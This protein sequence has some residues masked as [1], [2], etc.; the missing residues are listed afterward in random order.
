M[1]SFLAKFKV[2]D[3]FRRRPSKRILLL[4][5]G[6]AGKTTILRRL[7]SVVTDQL[8][9]GWSV[10]SVQCKHIEFVSWK[11][12]VHH[13]MCSHY[14]DD[15]GGIIFVVDSCIS[16]TAKDV[17]KDELRDLLEEYG[18]RGAVLL[19]L[20]NK[21]DIPESMDT[22]QVS[23][24]LGLDQIEDREWSVQGTCGQTGDGLQAAFDW[25]TNL[26]GESRLPLK[27]LDGSQSCDVSCV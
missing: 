27:R 22:E 10:E 14:Y 8:S 24:A 12:P 17:L 1:G 6:G 26:L 19:V 15:I 25:L 5:L 11:V 18:L 16:R 7:G 9:V 3:T 13:R 4:G 23:D 20:A 2:F 21:Q